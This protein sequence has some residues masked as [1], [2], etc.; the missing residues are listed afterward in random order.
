MKKRLYREYPEAVLK[1]LQVSQLEILKEFDGVCRKHGLKYFA[2]GGTLLG[3][4][5]HHGFIPWDDDV[6]LGMFREDW[7]RFLE[8]YR[9]EMPEYELISPETGTSFYAFTPKI[10]KRDTVFQSELAA[11]SGKAPGIYIEVFVF[12][13]VSPDPSVR[14]QQRK[15]VEKLRFWLFMSEMKHPYSLEGF[16]LSAAKNTAKKLLHIWS[17]IRGIS[18]EKLNRQFVEATV[19]KEETGVVGQ[20][21]DWTTEDWLCKK[22]D[23]LPLEDVPFESMKIPVQANY[24]SAL[25]KAYGSNYM[26]LPPKENRWNH[27]PK[28]I[29]FADGE[30]FHLDEV[31]IETGISQ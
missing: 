29:R 4:I 13:N 5:R 17:G 22:A 15:I 1:K 7:D 24:R 14:A 23:M 2:T 3:A 25:E 31:K 10:A 21:G 20:F 6:D 19:G 11:R 9:K 30:T 12:E 18:A 27:A 16:P 8:L 28:Y 26:E